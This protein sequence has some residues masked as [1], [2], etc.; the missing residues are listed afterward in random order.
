MMYEQD[1][2]FIT[3]SQLT[4]MPTLR[5]YLGTQNNYLWPNVL[6]Y[7]NSV[8]SFTYSLNNSNAKSTNIENAVSKLVNVI[9]FFK[10]FLF[11]LIQQF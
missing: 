8:V 7:L 5:F 3:F 2:I 6:F 4:E 11:D 1:R 10:L 9:I